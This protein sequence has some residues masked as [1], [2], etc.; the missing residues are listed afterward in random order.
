MILA[1]LR[2]SKENL[3]K[4]KENKRNQDW[5]TKY[6]ADQFFQHDLCSL[7]W[8]YLELENPKSS[9]SNCIGKLTFGAS[10]CLEQPWESYSRRAGCPGAQ[11][12]RPAPRITPRQP[13]AGRPGAQNQRPAPRIT[14]R[15]P[16]ALAKHPVLMPKRQTPTP[17]RGNCPKAQE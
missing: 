15:C 17:R 3:L 9:D 16:S 8:E 11:N 5:S 2:T 7:N 6:D 1:C 14:P 4:K 12:Q 13:R 10:I